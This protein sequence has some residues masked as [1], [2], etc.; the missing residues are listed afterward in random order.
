MPQAS[1]AADVSSDPAPPPEP[2]AHVTEPPQAT[3]PPTTADAATTPASDLLVPVLLSGPAATAATA[4]L[5]G[6]WH[7]AAWLSLGSERLEIPAL[8]RSPLV[9][10]TEA[11]DLRPNGRFRRSLGGT[12]AVGGRW[13]VTGT[14]TPPERLTWLGADTWWLVALDDVTVSL[15]PLEKRGREWVLAARDGED[16]LLVYL[17]KTASASEVTMGGRFTRR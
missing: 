2:T 12:L 9:P 10:P 14:V 4:L 11:W 6:D 7:L 8:R 1:E 17:G 16:A 5:H 3:T 13:I 15:N